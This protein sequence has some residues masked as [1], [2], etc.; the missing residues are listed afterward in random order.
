MTMN[1]RRP[2]EDGDLTRL[3]AQDAV[4]DEDAAFVAGVAARIAW[5]RSFAFGLPV[6]A[7]ALLL[8]SVWAT[9]PAAYAFSGAVMAGLRL[10]FAATQVFFTSPT[11]MLVAVVLLATGAAWT[12]LLE[13]VRGAG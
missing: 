6:A 3:F 9:W 13:R 12:W 11:G 2:M 8:L 7:T 4:P 5:R 10:I 1:E